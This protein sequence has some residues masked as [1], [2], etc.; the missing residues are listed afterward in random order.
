[1]STQARE[2]KLKQIKKMAFTAKEAISE[3]GFS[4]YELN[5]LV[6][7]GYLVKEGRGTFIKKNHANSESDHYAVAL[8]QLGEPSVLCLWSALVFHDLTEEAPS[9]IWAYVPYEKTTRLKIKA[10]RKR[11]PHWDIGIETIN[12]IRVTNI[13]RTLIDILLDRKHFPEVQAYKIVMDAIRVKK[14]AFQ[15]L[16]AMAKKLKADKRLKRDLLILEETRE[17]PHV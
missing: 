2:K 7:N 14:T 9:D 1:M 12:G 4:Y 8:T 3:A 16:F 5:L 11:N 10:V 17:A 13:E 15:K 6:K